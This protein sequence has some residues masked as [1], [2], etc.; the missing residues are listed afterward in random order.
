MV[1][2]NHIIFYALAPAISWSIIYRVA[3][4]SAFDIRNIGNIFM[5]IIIF[6]KNKGIPHLCLAFFCHIC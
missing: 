3:I 1:K 6:L 4:S 2:T 5:D